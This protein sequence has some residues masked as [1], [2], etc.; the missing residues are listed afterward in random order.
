MVR[1]VTPR[2][3]NLFLTRTQTLTTWLPLAMFAAGP[4]IF[5]AVFYSDPV[6]MNLPEDRP[7]FLPL[8]PLGLFLIIGAFYAWTLLSLPRRIIV[9]RDP[10]LV[11]KSVLRSQSVR[12]SDVLSIEPTHLNI[13]AGL[14]GYVLKHRDGKIRFPG[15]FTGQYILLSELKQAN[16]S[17]D[18][19]G[20]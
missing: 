1:A 6:A 15:Q 2:E 10:Q 17:V 12:V 3:Y 4:L 18:L 13:Q 19:K 16:P 11:F 14:S 20:C 7:P 8:L 5:L 9:T